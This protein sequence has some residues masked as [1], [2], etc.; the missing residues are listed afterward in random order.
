MPYLAAPDTPK[1]RL[2]TSDRVGPQDSREKEYLLPSG[3]SRVASSHPL[4]K[5]LHYVQ[6]A[7]F[8]VLVSGDMP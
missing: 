1:R 3:Y 5:Q 7:R 6:M 2:G 4:A 8:R